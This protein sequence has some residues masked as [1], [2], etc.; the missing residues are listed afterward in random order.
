MHKCKLN[1]PP[2]TPADTRTSNVTAE[3]IPDQIAQFIRL[4]IRSVPFL[5]AM[6]LLRSDGQHPWDGKRLARRLYIS[7]KAADK[8]LQELHRADM[9]LVSDEAIPSYRFHPASASLRCQIDQLADTYTLNTV[10][11]SKLIHSLA[12]IDAPA[13]KP[14]A[15]RSNQP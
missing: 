12:R 15:P 4:H 11:I 7:T 14:I 5:E 13:V 9:L 2:G 8:L 3:L 6:L 1:Q 10:A